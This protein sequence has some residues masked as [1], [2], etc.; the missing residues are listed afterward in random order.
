M[1]KIFDVPPP[2]QLVGPERDWPWLLATFGQ[3][4]QLT[5]RPRLADPGWVITEL[6]AQVGP[7]TLVACLRTAAGAPAAGIDVARWWADPLLLPLPAHL[8]Y[9]QPLGVYGPT[10]PQGDIGFAM[11]EGDGYDPGWPIDELPVSELWAPDNSDRIHGL[12]WIWGTNHKC[13]RVVFQHVTGDDPPPEP[14]PGDDVPT[15]LRRISADVD[16]LADLLA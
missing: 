1:L 13:I 6:H 3:A 12:G 16:R 14:P 15:I 9:W 2:G 7:S 5:T 10:N 11:G 8:A 4:I